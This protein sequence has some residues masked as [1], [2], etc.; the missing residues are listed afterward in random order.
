MSKTVKFYDST[1]RDGEQTPGVSF[2]TQQRVDIALSLDQAGVDQIEIGFAASGTTMRNDMKA[3]LKNKFQATTLSLSRADIA[4]VDAAIDVGV[5]GVIIFMGMSDIH[6]K[7][8][9][10]CSFENALEQIH[11]AAEYAKQQGLFVQI[12]AEDATRTQNE[13]L[14]AFCK[15]G[16]A[17]NVDRIGLADTVGIATPELI[18]D[19]IS[20]MVDAAGGID[21]SAHCHCDFGLGVANSIAAVR[22][23][24]AYL[25]TTINGI[26]ERSGNASMIE[27]VMA[28][29]KLYG[30]N[31]NI[32]LERM[33]QVS[34]LVEQYSGMNLPPHY[35]VVGANSFTHEAGIHVAALLKNPECYEAYD[36]RTVGRERKI[37]LGKT[38]GRAAIFHLATQI[39]KSLTSEE[40]DAI[41]EELQIRNIST[42]ENTMSTLTNLIEQQR[43]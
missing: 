14:E 8:K 12:S 31:T 34:K 25:S 13:R 30:Y 35:P 4:D 36:P 29:E 27:C 9:F 42:T 26:G 3:V 10:G 20:A 43:L 41:L 1:L 23:G 19:K 6:L 15:M 33:A 37:V 39:G 28:L 24:A 18:H 2:T 5:D 38:N 7:H 21:I 22:A 17:L 16:A 11:R 32:R 40:C